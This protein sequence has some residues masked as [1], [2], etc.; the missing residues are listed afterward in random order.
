[1]LRLL[2]DPRGRPSVTVRL[3]AAL[4]VLGMLLIAAPALMPV[5]RWA[6]SLVF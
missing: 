2:R 1:M 4:V 3:L 6:G 5:L